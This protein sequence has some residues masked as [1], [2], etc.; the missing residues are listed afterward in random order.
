MAHGCLYA[1]LPRVLQAWHAPSHEVG[2][3][4][5]RLGGR[6]TRLARHSPV[7]H[8]PAS[9][10][11]YFTFGQKVQ[12]IISDTGVD[13]IIFVFQMFSWLPTQRKNFFSCKI[14]RQWT[15]IT[16]NKYRTTGRTSKSSRWNFSSRNYFAWNFLTQKFPGLLWTRVPHHNNCMHVCGTWTITWN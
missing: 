2:A 8:W 7:P 5:W 10:R 6:P 9:A 14:F 15:I 12:C 16:A 11:G 13:E 3:P 1:A 4:S